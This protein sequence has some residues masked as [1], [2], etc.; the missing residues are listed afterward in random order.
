Q[1]HKEECRRSL[2]VQLWDDVIADAG[3][4]LRSLRR[5]P[6]FAIV[7]VLTLALGIGAN[8]AIFS[9]IDAVLLRRLPYPQQHR[10]VA[11]APQDVA[12]SVVLDGQPFTIV[13]VMPPQVG[14]PPGRD[15]WAPKI[16]TAVERRQRASS[17]FQVVASLRPGVSLSAAQARLDIVGRQLQR[18]YPRENGN[19]AIVVVP[20]KEA[21]VG[22]ARP[23]LTLFF[24]GVALLLVV[25]CANAGNLFLVRMHRRRQ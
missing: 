15:V 24:V 9:A 6:G 23:I 4:A 11:L 10:L 2:G 1:A 16:F 19:V 7:V 14:F 8:I 18:E 12:R 5:E 22:N 21:L 13:G 17:Y 20:L 25:A 3:Y